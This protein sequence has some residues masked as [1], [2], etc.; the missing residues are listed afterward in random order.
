MGIDH[1]ILYN[2]GLRAQLSAKGSLRR[3]GSGE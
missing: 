1:K 2:T 3:Q